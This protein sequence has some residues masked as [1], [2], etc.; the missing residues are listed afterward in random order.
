ML[1]RAFGFF[2]VRIWLEGILETAIYEAVSVLLADILCLVYEVMRRNV[3]GFFAAWKYGARTL[4][5][6]VLSLTLLIGAVDIL[7]L[8]RLRPADA[9]K[10]EE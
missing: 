7:Y 3:A 6:A 2:M 5:V 9:L 8:Q 4:G 10:A 1:K